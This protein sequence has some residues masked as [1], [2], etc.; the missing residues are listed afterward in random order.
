MD[1]QK[2]I[3]S[4]YAGCMV[5]AVAILDLG[6]GQLFEDRTSLIEPLQEKGVATK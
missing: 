4:L 6:H 3:N 5:N 2:R 1:A